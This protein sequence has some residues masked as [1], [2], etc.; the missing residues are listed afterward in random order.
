M[1]VFELPKHII[2]QEG[3]PLPTMEV[4]TKKSNLGVYTTQNPYILLVSIRNGYK[5]YH[6]YVSKGR[7][8]EL[9]NEMVGTILDDCE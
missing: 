2:V 4:V 3:D 9:L 5:V 7:A 1:S 8:H 6:Y